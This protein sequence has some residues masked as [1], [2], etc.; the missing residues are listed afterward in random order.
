MSLMFRW[1]GWLAMFRRVGMVAI[2]S[3]MVWSPD[4]LIISKPVGS[5]CFSLAKVGG[6]GRRDI[7]VAWGGGISAHL[8]CLFQTSI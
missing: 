5:A 4:W 7:E 3:C 2:F 8:I 6:P 1:K